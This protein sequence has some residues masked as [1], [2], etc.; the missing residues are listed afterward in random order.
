MHLLLLILLCLVPPLSHAENFLDRL[1]LLGGAKQNVI[2]PP[3][4]AFGLEV[5]ARDASTLLANFKITPGYYLY[6][7]KI[8]FNIPGD[9]A[10]AVSIKIT[11]VSM[12]KGEMKSD[13]NFGDMAVFHQSFQAVITLERNIDTAQ[14]VTLA[15]S[16]Q[17]CKEND[18]CY[19]PIDKQFSI[20]LPKANLAT[21]TVPMQPSLQ[22]A[23]N[24]AMPDDS[25]STQLA[26]L[27]KQGSFWLIVTFFFGA[28]LLLAFTPCVLPMIPILSGIIVGRSSHPTKMHGFLLSLAYVL[29]MALAYAAI[30]VAAGLSGTLLS[31]ALQTPWA[32]GSFAAVF[33][34][35]SLSMF[36]F[37]ELQLPAALQSKLT[38]TSNRLHG[39]H[40]S[41]VFVMGA[42]SA[43]IVSPCVAAPMAAALLY[44]GQTHDAWLGGTALFALA[45][46]M[47]LPLLL[48][49]A[50]AGALLPKAGAWMEAVKR[51]FGVL[52][53]A[54]AI[55]LISTLIPLSIQM[56]LW[57]ALL[58]LSA[59]YMH[60]LD[61][62]PNNASGWQKLWKGIGIL[63]LLLGSAYLIGALS[64]AR[65][66][67]RPLAAFG[68]GQ[69]AAA[70]TLQF[71]RVKNVAELDARIAQANGKTVML[72]FYADW[73]I[74][75][76]EMDRY[77]F[78]DAQVQ[79]KLKNAVLLQIDVTANSDE[80]KAV[81]KR[82]ELFGP[83]AILFFDAQGREQDVRR[84]I[85]YQ[86]AG[87]F[88]QSLSYAGL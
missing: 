24:V 31:S 9:S 58:V 10:K 29:G 59:I 18:L 6:R 67:L 61:A 36:G 12:P 75:C 33:V 49:G 17:G 88:L 4:K 77:T 39:G 80:D 26:K 63:A 53:L 19:A 55:W 7:D 68:N 66:I 65:D 30:G 8:R 54:L 81:L 45:M 74:S 48:I 73:C 27:F 57:A 78:T 28:G 69:V 71:V 60:A 40:L 56:L 43:I 85:G 41:G 64:G 37:Y 82:F 47:G 15:A 84:V 21:T 50:S 62:L 70:S 3:D 79:A 25:E 42:L 51:F 34:L 46:G 83:P 32:L 13:P 35:L 23:Q 1:P 38:T 16:Y 44:I 72:D 86:N 22:A 5:S 14:N 76:K 20:M 87:Q 11:N 52:M 2:L